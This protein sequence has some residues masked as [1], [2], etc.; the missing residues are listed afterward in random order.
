MKVK[1]VTLLE[2]IIVMAILGILSL[3]VVP[4]SMI[5]VQSVKEEELRQNLKTI[6]TAIKDYKIEA[7][8]KYFLLLR[9]YEDSGTNEGTAIQIIPP[10]QYYPEDLRVLV[11][12]TTTF[13]P[14]SDTGSITGLTPSGAVTRVKPLLNKLP[15][16]PFTGEAD[17]DI[18]YYP[19]NTAKFGSYVFDI[20]PNRPSDYTG[21][22]G[23]RSL[24][25]T[26]Y[27]DF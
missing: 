15:V 18:H 5:Q 20:S 2:M 21:P 9:D 24:G 16:D 26:L 10:W 4:Y 13:R 23:I 17:W 27:A 14:A 11:T 25:G 8:R 22:G 7:K 6:R 12:G 3:G 1:A 19:E